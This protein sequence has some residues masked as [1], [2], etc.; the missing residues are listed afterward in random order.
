MQA[1]EKTKRKQNSRPR[2]DKCLYV[3]AAVVGKVRSVECGDRAFERL[4]RRLLRVN[5]VA[6]LNEHND[7]EETHKELCWVELMNR[8]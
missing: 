1:G 2:V 3:G 4:L 5:A 6:T 8:Q 7:K